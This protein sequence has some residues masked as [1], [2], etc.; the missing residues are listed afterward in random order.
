MLHLT[1]EK[2]E[3]LPAAKFTR[4]HD[5]ALSHGL[6]A[7]DERFRRRGL[8][9]MFVARAG[10][11][12]PGLCYNLRPCVDEIAR[13]GGLNRGLNGLPRARP[14]WRHGGGGKTRGVSV[15]S[16]RNTLLGFFALL[17]VMVMPLRAFGLCGSRR[18]RQ[19]ATRDNHRLSP[20][21]TRLHWLCPVRV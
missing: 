4:M 1:G 7:Q 17:R 3:L 10:P 19:R 5:L 18:R 20:I 11:R 8:A 9:A 14:R 15:D 6:V 13:F 21:P 2:I 16:E 12:A